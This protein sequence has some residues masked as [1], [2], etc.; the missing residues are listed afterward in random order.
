MEISRNV[1]THDCHSF[2]GRKRC[3]E[4]SKKKKIWLLIM[5]TLF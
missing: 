4:T 1:I 3:T 2:S 5:I